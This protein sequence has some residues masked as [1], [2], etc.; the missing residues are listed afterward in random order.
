VTDAS[1]FEREQHQTPSVVGV[2]LVEEELTGDDMDF[3]EDDLA[4]MFANL[5]DFERDE[6]DW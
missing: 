3:D 2:D 4:E 5:K 6:R 1:E